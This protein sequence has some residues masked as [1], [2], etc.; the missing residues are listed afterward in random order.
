MASGSLVS[1]PLSPSGTANPPARGSEFLDRQIQRTR[2]Q[3]KQVELIQRGVVLL[4]LGLAFFLGMAVL[5]HWVIPG[6]LGTIGRVL[7]WVAL[8][9][10]GG[11]YAWQFFWPLV[12]YR[13]NPYYAAR[14][15]E[16]TRPTLKNSLIN[17]LWFRQHQQD[18][19][20]AIYQAL[21]KQ[22][23]SGIH[24]LSIE[25]TVDRQQIIRWGYVLV[26]LVLAFALYFLISPKNPFQTAT[27]VVFPWAD[28]DQPTR[29]RIDTLTPGDA[30][31]FRGQSVT[32]SAEI[33]GLH[34]DEPVT[35]YYTTT[36]ESQLDQPVALTPGEGVKRFQCQ[37]PVPA[38]QGEATVNPTDPTKRGLQQSLRYYVVAGDAKSDV[39][40]VTV[41]PA[42]NLFVEKLEFHYPQYTGLPVETRGGEGDIAALEGTR[43]KI[44][45]SSNQPIGSA[46]LELTAAEKPI[47]LPLKAQD[48]SAT[49]ELE[50][51][52]ADRAAG[53]PQF[54]SYVPR[55][56]NTSQQAN[57]DPIRHTIKVLRDESPLVDLLEPKS[58]EITV[59]V[60]QICKFEVL[61][62]DPDF[63]LQYVKLIG[64]KGGKPAF[65][66]NLLA[67]AATL[68][69]GEK[70]QKV[71][72]RRP[73]DWGL[74]VG[75]VIEVYAEAADNKHPHANITQSTRRTLRVVAPQQP[76]N[77][78][79][80]PPNNQQQPPQQPQNQQPN[81][82][83]KNPGNPPPMPGEMGN[84]PPNEQNPEQQNNP[85][86]QINPEQKN[87]GQPNNQPG[88]MGQ[89]QGPQ[90]PNQSQPPPGQGNQGSGDPT[91]MNSGNDPTQNPQPSG[92]NT[93]QNNSN[94]QNNSGQPN[95]PG[96]S[97]NSN[98]QQSPNQAMQP[99]Q[100]NS[101]DNNQNPSP[102][103]ANPQMGDANPQNPSQPNN[104]SQ[105]NM[106][107]GAQPPMGQN[108]NEQSP[109]ANTAQN[110]GG[111]TNPADMNQDNTGANDS[112]PP[113]MGDQQNSTGGSSQQNKSGG[114]GADN[115]QPLKNDGSSDGDIFDK[116]QRN[117]EF[118][119]LQKEL[120]QQSKSPGDNAP[121][122]QTPP[123]Q[124]PPSANSNK[125]D[126]NSQNSNNQ[127]GNMGNAAQP[128]M[129]QDNSP[130]NS[131]KT[132]GKTDQG[133]EKNSSPM[134]SA[135]QNATE[136]GTSNKPTNTPPTNSGMNP[137]AEM[138]PSPNNGDA[139]NMNSAQPMNSSQ[140]MP[141][142]NQ[143]P[144]PGNQQSAT[145][146][147]NT[148]NNQ[149]EKN[150]GEKNNTEKSG[151]QQSQ[152]SD[153]P[154]GNSGS[155]GKQANTQK[156][157]ATDPNN[158]QNPNNT[159]A[160]GKS[161]SPMGSP[162]AQE[163]GKTN[164]KT[165]MGNP[166]SKTNEQSPSNK[167]N[168]SST[169]GEEAGDRNGGGQQGGGQKSPQAGR[170]SAGSQMSDPEGANAS[171]EQG[172]GET[173]TQAGDQQTADKPTGKS[174]GNQAG[175]GS[176]SG[177]KTGGDPEQNPGDPPAATGEK[178]MNQPQPEKAQPDKA[179]S[180]KSNPANKGSNQKNPGDQSANNQ[181]PG[182]KEPP[183]DKSNNQDPAGKAGE[184]PGDQPGM[185]RSSLPREGGDTPVDPNAPLAPADVSGPDTEED[186]ANLEYSQKATDLMLD[187]LKKQLDKKQVDQKLLDELG[188]TPDDLQ[189]FVNRWEQMRKAA[190]N[191]DPAGKAAQQKLQEKLRSLGLRPPQATRAGD[192]KSDD[193]A[194]GNRESRKTAPPPEY[195]ELYKAYQKGAAGG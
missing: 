152:K 67:N 106:G 155:Q 161:G 165:A 80:P 117:P 26:G 124:S 163:K 75:D 48:Q 20:E 85:N 151:N 145:E 149:P 16:E 176:Q 156:G 10:G 188:W 129:P 12:Q 136:K 192:S 98:Q 141:G 59:P 153:M 13:I 195:R 69:A 164:S 147:N 100:Q 55:F 187:R 81:Q 50:L 86:Q 77:M 91:G 193:T 109:S 127:Q 181:Q 83:Q 95:N 123:E 8:L 19:P 58:A 183:N 60:D 36:D 99:G 157:D 14:T 125:S 190:Q 25:T 18:V 79:N 113:P 110:P 93:P 9:A 51:Q 24:D 35:L 70:L 118:Q 134:S 29:V 146:K 45:T 28:V 4:V 5:D 166:D 115:Q 89:N 132:P 172:M 139:Q 189:K 52:F 73:R 64:L 43:V 34:T 30:H 191:D 168:D 11:W 131:Q 56:L 22:A 174:A 119:D 88:N 126:K 40:T 138:N 62:S 94:P 159:D 108:S 177:N 23:A 46:W 37:L 194:R 44:F 71:D 120:N 130:K 49:G 178:G 144:T 135:E 61:A 66:D 173:G 96:Q 1:P 148:D 54:T 158:R 27:R 33:S 185:G 102:N 90:D 97:S 184:Q 39:Y 182:G 84:P 74:K 167:G 76:Q 53:L 7:G 116:L 101:A 170:G 72:A 105:G 175:N 137:S 78:G 57:P 160:N 32:I 143:S 104:S 112:S 133:G 179:A 142:G 107:E 82:D 6:G 180:E 154:P 65:T 128:D 3:V 169:S 122:N 31:V 111:N 47:K 87:N 41:T 92:Q 63:G 38:P 103:G 21:E 171:S 150:N 17:Y 15:I 162:D 186:A 121:Q 68:R 140:P 2:A 114:R 42:P